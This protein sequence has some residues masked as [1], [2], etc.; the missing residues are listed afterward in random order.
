[1][2]LSELFEASTEVGIIFGRFNPPHKGHKAAWEIA[3][4]SPI[5]FVGTNKS[6]IG[7]KDPLPFDVKVEAMKVIWPDIEGHIVTEQSWLTLCST[8]F[9][10]YGDVTLNVVTDEEYVFKLIAQYNGVEGKAHGFYK[11]SNI[12]PTPSPRI[13]SATDLRNAVMAGDRDA[14]AKAAGVAADTIVAGT[15]F[16][17]LVAKYLT[18]YLDKKAAAPAPKKAAAKKVVK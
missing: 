11:F 15:P 18:P 1:M 14:F 6:T 13:S 9:S 10:E 16:F 8:V 5:W 17:D 2:L 3:A 12:V 7:P 4:K